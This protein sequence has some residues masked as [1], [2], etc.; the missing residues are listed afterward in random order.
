[1]TRNVVR[2]ERNAAR[3]RAAAV[4]L[5]VLLAGC[6]PRLEPAAFAGAEPRF[7]PERFFEGT[8]RSTGVIE[9]RSGGPTERVATESVG[10]R[11]GDALVVVQTLT[12][13]DGRR[14]ERR[15][16]L[17]RLDAHRYEATANDIVGTAHGQAHRDLYHHS[18]T[19]ATEP[20]NPLKNVRF[21][22]WMYLQ[23]DGTMVNRTIV[24]KFGVIIAQVTEHFR[25]ATDAQSS[26]RPH[27]SAL[28][29]H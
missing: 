7:A 24:T 15:W 23:P 1:M 27:R 19:L 8:V 11:E 13:G 21:E 9:D 17:R 5:A 14:Q 28:T 2:Q 25:R 6:S 20:G 4:V 26:R 12:F 16:R 18:F 3:G 10:R 29:Q 22:Q